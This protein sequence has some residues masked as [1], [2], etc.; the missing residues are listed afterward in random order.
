MNPSQHPAPP[1]GPDLRGHLLDDRYVLEV[2]IGCGGSGNVYAARDRRLRR[3]VAVKVI[4][5]ELARTE[6]Q[7]QR[8]RQEA[9]V[10]AQIAHPHVATVLDLG[11]DQGLGHE[12]LMYLVMPLLEGRTLRAVVLDGAI[13]WRSAALWTRQLLAGLAALHA[14][15]V[16][17]RDIKVDNCLLVREG[18]REVL[19][20]VDLGLAK[21]TRDDL[22]TRPP[23]SSRGQVI[24]TLPYISP[25]QAL[26]EPVDERSDLYAAGVVLFELLT[27]R[28]PFVGSDYEVLV[29]HV[30]RPP[31]APS[32][33][34]PLACI[35]PALDEVVLRALAKSRDERFAA[36]IDFDR[37]LASAL[38]S[39]GVEIERGPEL[40]G[41]LEAQASLAAWAGFERGRARSEADLAARLNRAWS[42]LSLLLSLVPEE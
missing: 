35:P 20:I 17:H 4:H 25:E 30:E 34:A 16:L 28:P 8:I 31:P 27:R 26:G 36:A 23:I 5:P 29:G 15:G 3:R 19:K 37:A 22:L 24:G 14:R 32:E 7:R 11:E 13:A 40:A 1:R 38:E 21:L 33:V 18:E 6:A 9:L 39:S 12:P 10:G 42:P 41:C 2:L